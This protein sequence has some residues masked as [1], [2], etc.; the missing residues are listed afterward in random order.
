MIDFGCMEIVPLVGL[1]PVKFGMN[2]RQVKA[3]LGEKLTWEPWM[4][5]NR[6]EDL[7]YPGLAVSFDQFGVDEFQIR[8][9]LDA[10]WMG[11]PVA[12]VTASE[13]MDALTAMGAT[14]KWHAVGMVDSAKL[15]ITFEFNDDGS[16]SQII[17]S[18]TVEA[19]K[20]RRRWW[21]FWKL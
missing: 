3:F 15:A 2:R 21:Q 17:M 20:S 11:R 19:Q 5:G 10:T 9:S 18:T 4:G 7:Y 13:V 14:P 6:N 16:L 8:A 12:E 1:G